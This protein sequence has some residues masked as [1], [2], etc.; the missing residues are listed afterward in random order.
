[1]DT[2]YVDEIAAAIER[3]LA[4]ELRPKERGRELYRYYALLVLTTGHATTLENVHDAW[5]AWMS[6]D[7]PM[8]PSLIPFTQLSKD[9]QE[10]DRP[11]MEAIRRISRDSSSL[12]SN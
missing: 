9:K 11:Y 6:A 5:S 7:Q 10:Q 2:S 4:V 1:M 8:H 12:R 3:E